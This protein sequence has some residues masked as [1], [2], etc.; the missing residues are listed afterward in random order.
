MNLL[1]FYCSLGISCSENTKAAF[2]AAF[3]SIK[4]LIYL[5]IWKKGKT[6]LL[7]GLFSSAS[8]SVFA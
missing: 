7:S 1:L 6:F 5:K 8:T 4:Y 3:I 2:A